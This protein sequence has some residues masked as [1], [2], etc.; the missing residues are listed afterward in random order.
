MR[1]TVLGTRGSMAVSNEKMREFGGATSSY[2]VEEDGEVLFF[3]AGRGIMNIPEGTVSGKQIWLLITHTH[4]DHIMGMPFFLSDFCGGKCL[5]IYGRSREGET[6]ERQL[7][8]LFSRPLWPVG[9]RDYSGIRI[10]CHELDGEIKAGP[11]RITWTESQH[12][13]GAVN[14]RVDAG[15]KSVV[16][17]TDFEHSSGSEERLVAFSRDADLLLYDGQ[18]TEKEYPTFRGFGHSTPETGLQVFRKS[19]A[20]RMR[21]VHHAPDATDEELKRRERLLKAQEPNA[22]FARE[23]EVLEL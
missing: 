15:G 8:H 9:L 10:V 17:A 14:Y 13:G 23:G 20:K 3:D 11:F 21:I 5:N 4:L 6:V 7:R 2:M 19:G 18:Y 16:L 1:V 22:G 12:P